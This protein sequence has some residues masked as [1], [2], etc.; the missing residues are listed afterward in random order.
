MSYDFNNVNVLVVE[1]STAM[2]QL[3]KGVLTMLSIPQKNIHA[4]YDLDEAFEKFC[5]MKHDII[6]SDWLNNPDHGIQLTKKVRTHPNS[7]DK[8][9][10]IIM[11]AGS[12]HYS[13]VISARDSGISEYLVKPFAAG[14]LAKRIVRVIE[15]PKIFVT[16]DAYS[17]PDRRVR[18]VPYKG[19][20]RRKPPPELVYE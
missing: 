10:P 20:D 4:A 18:E 12:G 14:D 2:Y 5:T 13:R 19:P 9:V 1:S 17:G 16:S 15:A 11:T 3:I 7:P 8:Y 6:L